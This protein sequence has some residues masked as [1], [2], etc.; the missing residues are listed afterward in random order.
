MTNKTIRSQKHVR[1]RERNEVR[2]PHSSWSRHENAKGQALIAPA[3]FWSRL[4]L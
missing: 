1:H 2:I 3:D 4:G